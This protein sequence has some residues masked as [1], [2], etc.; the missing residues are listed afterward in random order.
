MEDANSHFRTPIAAP[1]TV[2]LGIRPLSSLVDEQVI[3]SI[4]FSTTASQNT[5]P[6]SS[7][8]TL[9]KPPSPATAT[10]PPQ[11]IEIREEEVPS[12]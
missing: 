5:T 3:T 9:A 10:S 1:G 8:S 4:A 12:S 2:R 6:S 7:P 11:T